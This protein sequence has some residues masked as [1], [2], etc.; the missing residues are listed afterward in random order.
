MILA[1]VITAAVLTVA[2]PVALMTAVLWP[3][4]IGRHE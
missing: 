4:Y 2:G 3:A 1:A